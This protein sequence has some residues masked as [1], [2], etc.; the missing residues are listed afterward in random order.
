MGSLNGTWKDLRHFT[1]EIN[2]P[3]VSFEV[4]LECQVDL[5]RKAHVEPLFDECR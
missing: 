3:A 1:Q 2:A 5:L 4:I